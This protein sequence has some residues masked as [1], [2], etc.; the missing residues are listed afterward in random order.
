M[1]DRKEIQANYFSYFKLEHNMG[2]HPAPTRVVEWAFDLLRDRGK[3][4]VPHIKTFEVVKPK[5]SIERKGEKF[6]L[7]V[8]GQ[9][10]PQNSL[11]GYTLSYLI[12]HP[13]NYRPIK[14][15]DVRH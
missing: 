4:V 9:Y 1:I 8:F 12:A 10:C 14:A 15:C 13:D 2:H 11:R 7:T 6:H 3:D 5:N